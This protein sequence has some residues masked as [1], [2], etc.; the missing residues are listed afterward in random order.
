[1]KK[2]PPLAFCIIMDVL[3]MA[4][5]AVPVLGE[6]ADVIWAPLSALIFFLSFGGKKAM[7]GAAFN[8]VEELIPGTDFIP[9]FTIAWIWQYFSQRNKSIVS[10]QR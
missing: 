7:Y 2:Q 3:G 4:T 10:V 5:Y 9:T 8:L 6:F 1:M